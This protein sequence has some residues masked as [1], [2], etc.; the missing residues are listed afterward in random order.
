MSSPFDMAGVVRSKSR[1]GLCWAGRVVVSPLQR[2]TLAKQTN[3]TQ[4]LV[5][6]HGRAVVIVIQ[7]PRAG[8]RDSP[9]VLACRVIL[10]VIVVFL[11]LIHIQLGARDCARAFPSR[12]GLSA[13]L[14]G[15]LALRLNATP[16]TLHSHHNIK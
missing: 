14:L 8:H 4:G 15:P 3:Q 12:A 5:G 1:P 10:T 16:S 11:I 9:I 6:E 13:F 2:Q 7:L